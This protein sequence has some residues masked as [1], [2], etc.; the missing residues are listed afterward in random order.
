MQILQ[1][2]KEQCSQLHLQRRLLLNVQKILLQRSLLLRRILDLEV[3]VRFGGLLLRDAL[4]L[5]R[6]RRLGVG[7]GGSVRGERANFTRL[8]LGCIEAKFCK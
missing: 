5:L 7:P 1:P 3:Q 6:A 8:V 4:R 2:H